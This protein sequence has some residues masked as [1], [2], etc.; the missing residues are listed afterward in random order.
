MGRGGSQGGGLLCA[1]AARQAVELGKA[2]EGPGLGQLL[3][4]VVLEHEGL[5]GQRGRPLLLAVAED[6]SALSTTPCGNMDG[7][8]I[9]WTDTE[10]TGEGAQKQ[11]TMLPGDGERGG[12]DLGCRI[13]WGRVIQDCGLGHGSPLLL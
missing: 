12:Q 7:E 3:G 1:A 6:R 9:R 2:V 5:D 4:E 8:G 13:E 10:P 11:E